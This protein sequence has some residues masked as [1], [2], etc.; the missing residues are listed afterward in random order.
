MT[1]KKNH[2]IIPRVYQKEFVDPSKPDDFP[3][4]TPYTPTIWKIDKSLELEPTRKS[5]EKSFGKNKFYKLDN[6]R[7]EYQIIEETLS[8]IESK[9]SN[10]LN[11]IKDKRPLFFPDLINLIVFIETLHQRTES[12]IGHWQ[13]TFGEI[14][15]IYRQVEQTNNNNQEYSD[16][17]WKDSHEIAKRLIITTI[18]AMGELIA[19]EG[20]NILF[21]ESEMPFISS[22][23]PVLWI[24][25]HID[26]LIMSNIP[27]NWFK[28][29]IKTNQM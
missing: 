18:G 10:V 15:N 12:Q 14:E 4:N 11:K 16:E 1:V 9:F 6:D 5:P 2:H 27:R 22:D 19:N 8:G 21:N 20:I 23:N 26:E 25:G 13:N 24:H 28:E 7:D 29:G 3:E 17:F